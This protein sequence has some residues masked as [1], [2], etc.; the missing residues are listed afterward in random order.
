MNGLLAFVIILVLPFSNAEA[1][2]SVSSDLKDLYFGEALYHAYQGEW[3]DAISRLDTEIPGYYRVD[4]PEKDTLHFHI[5]QA[6]F[7]VGD[8]ELHYRMHQRAGRAIKSVIEGNVPELVRNEAIYRLARMYFQKDRPEDALK[9]VNLVRGSIP[10][11]IRPEFVYL[12]SNINMANGRNGEAALALKD[13]ISD[14][15]MEG[16]SSYNMGIALIRDGKEQSGR[17]YLDKAGRV[18]KSD[19]ATLSIKDKANLV[20]GEKLMADKNYESAKSVLD[21]VRIDGPFSNRALLGSGWADAYQDQYESALVPWTILAERG[22]T[23]ESTEEAMLALPYAYG[24]LGVYSKA[25]VLYD[26]A[27]QTFGTE[28]DR[29]NA[30]ITSIHEG[31]FLKALVREEIKLD[32]NWV[33]KLRELPESPETFY[34]LDLMA[35]HD[36]QETLKNYLDLEEL[37][38]KIEVWSG[39]IVAFEDIIEKRKA[40]YQPLLPQ[41]DKEFR[42]LDSKMRLRL[43]QRDLI[44]KRL[45]GMLTAPHPEYLATAADRIALDE[46]TRV[47]KKLS[48]GGKAVPADAAARIKRLRGV[49]R[50]GI[51]TEYDRRFTDAHRHLRDLNND[52]A[53]LKKAYISFVRARQAATQSYEGYNKII[54]TLKSRIAAAQSKVME[55]MPKQ[56][57]ILTNMA[58]SELSKRRDRITEYQTKAHFAMA[59]SFD[60]ATRAQEKVI[61]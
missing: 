15:S 33:V 16:F 46:V 7:D 35:S 59:D 9:T 36:F 28:I 12:R 40:Y 4:E 44:E 34:L 1:G 26:K 6:T 42:R 54:H 49:I 27:V 60:R 2:T 10:A 31:K 37:R 57:E 3:F 22:T 53:R 52:M 47:E 17:E 29:L 58:V 25:A 5:N 55:L 45:H 23:D 13:I 61:K 48:A 39:D 19:E 50:F 11:D 56:G 43:M 14:K 24:K 32:P 30:S 21:R 20:L 41:V 51:Y 18:E 8:F 38:K